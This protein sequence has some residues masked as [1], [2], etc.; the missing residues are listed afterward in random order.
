MSGNLIFL[1]E[2]GRALQLVQHHIAEVLRVNAAN[3]AICDE[4]GIT[5][6]TTDQFTGVLTGVV[7]P[8]VV[9]QGWTK[10][11]RS[12][13]SFPKKGSEWAQRMRDQ[14]GY[15]NPSVAIEEAFAIPTD[16]EY[17][18]AGGG[19]GCRAIGNIF[20]PCGFLYLSKDGPY[21]LYIPD[22][23]AA[24]REATARGEDALEPAKSYV[25]AIEGCRQIDEEEWDLLVAQHNLAK[26]RSEHQPAASA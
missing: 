11:S 8:G 21:A 7:F 20:K 3:R 4:L 17:T 22:V 13:C 12:G 24:V 5:K 10:P 25:P 6:G 14:K 15:D 9:A 1:I 23:Q 2:A 18:N 26:K 19:N 16:L